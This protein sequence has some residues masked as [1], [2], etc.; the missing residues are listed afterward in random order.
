MHTW[1]SNVSSQLKTSTKRPSWLPRAFTDSV[2]P[3]PAGPRNH[4][5]Q[6]VQNAN[7]VNATSKVCKCSFTHTS[8]KLHAITCIYRCSVVRL[9]SVFNSTALVQLKIASDFIFYTSDSGNHP[10]CWCCSAP[11]ADVKVY[12][13]H[14]LKSPVLYSPVNG[15]EHVRITLRGR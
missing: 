5:T 4:T 9:T 6:V 11:T 8:Q 7:R 12:M 13:W 3:V 15:L 1:K 14:V 2:L 10:T